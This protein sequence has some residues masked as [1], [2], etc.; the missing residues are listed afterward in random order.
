MVLARSMGGEAL[1]AAR[2]ANRAGTAPSMQSTIYE[3]I[4]DVGAERIALLTGSLLDYSYGLLRVLERTL[5]G[6]LEVKYLVVEEGSELLTFTPVVLG[7]EID[8]NATMPSLMRRAYTKSLEWLGQ[9]MA[10]HVAIVG[11]LISD[12]GW[13][14]VH[15]KCDSREVVEVLLRALDDFNRRQGVDMC[16]IKDLPVDYPHLD[17]VW[18]A[19]FMEIFSL[20]SVTLETAFESF[21][22]YVASLS[23]NGRSHARRTLRKAAETMT[24]RAVDDYA[25]LIPE[26]FPLFRATFFKAPIKFEE[27]GPD[28]F[29]E[30]AR[31]ESPKSEIVLAERRGK[32][33][34]FYL[35]FYTDDVQHNKRVGIDYSQADSALVYNALNYYC[36][37]RAIERGITLCSLGQTSYTLKRRLGGQLKDMLVPAKGYTIGAR[38]GLPLHRRTMERYRAAC[39]LDANGE[40]G[41]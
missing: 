35:V 24:L 20:P 2:R 29:K 11:S 9:S 34:G 6:D 37:R 18:R 25:A 31:L 16:V 4:D 39:Y 21:D 15:S 28:F 8:L 23:S 30:C 3:R 14:P 10:Y 33:I 22:A 1:T 5:W 13:F 32:T 17:A 36:I 7:T 26:C 41:R 27:L 12:L 40:H 19:G 38:L